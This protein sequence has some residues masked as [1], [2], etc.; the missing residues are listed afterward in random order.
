MHEMALSHSFDVGSDWRDVQEKRRQQR[1]ERMLHSMKISFL[2][3][4]LGL[5][6]KIKTYSM[7]RRLRL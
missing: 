7:R 2:G 1:D 4:L 5:F 6:M 3:S